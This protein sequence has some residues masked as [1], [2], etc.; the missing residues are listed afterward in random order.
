M[1]TIRETDIDF[2]KY[3]EHPE[4]AFVKPI[5]AWMTE[6]KAELHGERKYLGH[7]MPWSK[8]H[9]KFVFRRGELTT[10][11][12]MNGHKKSML[13]SQV[14]LSLAS[15]GQRICI[16]S[17]EMPPEDTAIRLIRMAAGSENIPDSFVDRFLQWAHNR[18]WIYD[19]IGTVPS[20]R[21]L[22]VARYAH[23]ELKVDHYVIDSLMKCGVSTDGP[24]WMSEQRKFIDAL[25][26]HAKNTGQHVHLIAH[27]RKPGRETDAQDKYGI[28]GS[29]DISNMSDNVL[30]VWDN[31]EKHY[32]K[33]HGD[34]VD[35][36]KPDL[37]LTV[38][39]QR[40][41]KWEGKVGLWLHQ[42]SMQHVADYGKGPIEVM[43]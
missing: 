16:A 42:D 43:K 10:W 37:V 12:G 13:N 20:G 30:L 21:V 36:T 24:G 23:E 33:S 6:I 31:K 38:A 3:L 41:G 5:D 8:T 11:A 26:T 14:M 28:S 19:Q 4:S 27:M 2:N 9:D 17:F 35:E 1:Q 32:A 39:K 40:K 18:I 15:E 34:D 29:A 25:Q 7:S 22:A